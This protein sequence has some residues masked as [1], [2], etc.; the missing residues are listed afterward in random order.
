M[1]ALLERMRQLPAQP[2]TA[3]PRKGLNALKALRATERV[4]LL[5]ISG[6]GDV[7]DTYV[8]T[9]AFDVLATPYH[10]NSAWQ[11]R[12]RLR[13]ARDA[14]VDAMKAFA[15]APT[16]TAGA[17]S[18]EANLSATNDPFYSALAREVEMVPMNG[19]SAAVAGRRRR[20]P[21]RR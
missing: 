14:V 12:S 3:I 19:G 20:V 15:E 13:A 1:S 6:D 18:I 11:V 16:S 17:K 7:M 8:S 5:G 10:V 4:R 2:R 21:I 9:G